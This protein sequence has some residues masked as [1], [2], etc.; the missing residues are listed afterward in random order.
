MWAWI[1]IEIQFDSW[2]PPQTPLFS[3]ENLSPFSLPNSFYST[4]TVYWSSITSK[5]HN[6][7]DTHFNIWIL[8]YRIICTRWSG[9]T[10]SWLG[11]HW[12]ADVGVKLSKCFCLKFP[13]F[14]YVSILRFYHSS[15]SFAFNDEPKHMFH[16]IR[17]RIISCQNSHPGC[18]WSYCRV[19]VRICLCY[20]N[21]LIT[22]QY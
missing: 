19:V 13:N 2:A 10:L 21:S 17:R 9:L 16:G 20:S 12:I 5:L 8:L 18:L 14:H 15:F 1:Q 7:I 3:E 11:G 6:F 4:H 22:T